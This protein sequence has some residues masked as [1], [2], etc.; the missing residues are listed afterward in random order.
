MTHPILNAMKNELERTQGRL[1]SPGHPPAYFISY[2]IRQAD[3]FNIWGRYG[4][5]CKKGKSRKRYCYTDIRVGDPQYD[6]VTKGGL[7]DNSDQTESFELFEIPNSDDQDVLQ[8]ALWRLTDAK[9]REAVESYHSRKSRDVSFLDENK[10]FGSLNLVNADESLLTVSELKVDKEHWEKYIESSSVIPKSYAEI[11][12][13]YC[14]LNVVRQTKFFISTEG[15]VRSWQEDHVS[16]VC[17][18][19]LHT[20]KADFERSIVINTLSADELPDIDTFSTMIHDKIKWMISLQE[21]AE[22]NSFSGPALLAPQAAGVL[23]HEAMGH[24]L[25]G[26]RML[27]DDEGRTFK[28][29]I[30]KKITTH[31]LSVYD[32]PSQKKFGDQGMYGYYSFDDEAIPSQKVQLVEKGVLK[33][34]LSSR[35]PYQNKHV[36]NGHGRNQTFERP[37]SRMGNLMIEPHD[38]KSFSELKKDLLELINAQNK[39]FGII[40]MDVQGGET[41]TEAYDFQ[42][43]LGD[44]THAIKLNADGTEEIIRGAD[45]VGTPLSSL[46]NIVEVGDVQELD[47]SFCGAESGNVPV[48]TVAPALLL[49]NLE[50][51]TKDTTKMTQY[52]L[53]MPWFDKR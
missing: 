22:I 45:F 42:A 9:Y 19:W 11:K 38:G 15:V 12:N 48:S 2:L 24:R 16:L 40:L 50:L 41:G 20:E 6:Q 4:S 18:L 36:S 47:N 10:K 7:M 32:D 34:F 1:K 49:S 53:P 17:Y 8:F 21:C 28:D 3:K 51:Q 43:F 33:N 13:S 5:I 25:E 27:S 37:I 29:K 26:S 31:K 44:I 52:A 30:G 39:E 23:I 14:D 46:G 35:A